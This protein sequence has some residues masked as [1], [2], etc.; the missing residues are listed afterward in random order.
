MNNIRWE[1]IDRKRGEY[2][3]YYSYTFRTDYDD[4]IVTM[5]AQQLR[6]R[7]INMNI[8]NLRMGNDGKIRLLKDRTLEN[9]R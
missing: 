2:G 8:V 1:C 9:T 7:W 4:Q 5:S 6:A 3:G